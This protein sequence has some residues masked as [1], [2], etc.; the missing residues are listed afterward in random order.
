MTFCFLNRSKIERLS[1]IFNQKRRV[2]TQLTTKGLFLKYT[3]HPLPHFSFQKTM[4]FIF[5][6]ML[7]SLLALLNFHTDFALVVPY[8]V[9]VDAPAQ[10]REQENL[11]L[12]AL[13]PPPREFSVSFYS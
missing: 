13:R 11:F 6:Q 3:R 10:T 1:D 9:L 12:P 2:D 7:A 8:L 4:N 5:V